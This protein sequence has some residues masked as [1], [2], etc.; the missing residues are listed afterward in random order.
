[1]APRK[2][3]RAGSRA[4]KAPVK[5]KPPINRGVAQSTIPEDMEILDEHKGSFDDFNSPVSELEDLTADDLPKGSDSLLYD[6][7]QRMDLVDQE[8]YIMLYKYD[9]DHGEMKTHCRRYVGEIPN[10]DGVGKEYGGG[11][12]CLILTARDK[13]GNMRGTTRKFK[14]HKS[15]DKYLNK[16]NGAFPMINMGGNSGNGGNQLQDAVNLVRV[17]MQTF[18]PM[19]QMIQQNQ[20]Q[21][22][23]PQ[24]IMP[25][26]VGEMM[27]DNYKTMNEAMKEMMLDNTQLYNDMSRRAV[28]LPETAETETE[29]SGVLGVFNT[30][31][32]FVEKLLPMVTQ[33]GAQGMQA[34]KTIQE[35]PGFKNAIKDKATIKNLYDFIEKKHGTTT[36]KQILQKFKLKSPYKKPMGRPPITEV[37]K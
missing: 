27:A 19:V 34:V 22:Q 25:E 23:S 18:M 16:E 33:R 31:L 9:R 26:N 10:E 29:N 28:D 32:P 24:N 1:M 37:K 12:Y 3:S 20:A 7:L 15:Y 2:Q 36:A 4:R 13:H 17:M 6:Y 35:M 30:I 11:R 14:L 8:Y 5:K 21:P